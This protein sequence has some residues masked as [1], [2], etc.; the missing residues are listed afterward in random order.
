MAEAVASN[1]RAPILRRVGS[2]F[3]ILSWA[4]TY[5]RRWLRPD[6]VAGVTVAAFAIPEDMAYASLAGL[7]PQHA[8]YANL[9][10]LLVYAA[11]GTSRQLSY[12]VTSALSIMVAGTLGTMAFSSPD[13]YAA[14]AA[15]VAILSGI[16]ALLAGLFRIGFIVNFVSESVLTGFSAGAALYIAASQVSKLFGI[17]GVQGNFFERIWN[18]LRNIGDTN[19]WTL[20]VGAMS[21]AALL[22]LERAFPRLP[23]SLIV[24]IIAIAVMWTSNLEDR[25][26]EVAG[27]IPGGLPTPAWPSIASDQLNTLVVLAFGAFLL[28]Y[29]EGVGA[30]RT[31][32][33]RH[34]YHI[35]SNQELFAN[36]GANLAA[37]MLQ[38][39]NV[40][41]SMSRSAVNE[42]AGSRTPMSSLFAA[43]VLAL[44]LLFLTEPFSHL[45]ETTLAAIVIVA[46]KGLIDI[47][48]LK[49]LFDISRAEFLAALLTMLGVLTFGMLGGIIIGVLVSFLT[50]LKRVSLPRISLL[51]LNPGTSDF[52]DVNHNPDAQVFP[53][54]AVFRPDTGLFY[55]NIPVI[56]DELAKAIEQREEP[57]RLVV[58]DLASAPMVDLETVD[59]LGEIAD[60]LDGKEI[61]LRLA[62][63]HTGVHDLLVKAGFTDRHGA[64]APHE[65]IAEVIASWRVN[66]NHAGTSTSIPS[67]ERS[68]HE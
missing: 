29:V 12:S 58:V 63:V 6:L 53:D 15:M 45:P 34:K 35:D 18:V 37:G 50:V 52:V 43:V 25:G 27:S 11:M 51:G 19:G 26:I 13:Q 55:G 21:M 30:A 64:V 66:G 48:G 56:K 60:D 24:T 22:A 57:P 7:Q 20:A 10:A 2:V 14:A 31:F 54:I 33:I 49:R 3:P 17:S 39:Y 61:D 23:T 5:D 41:G 9:V 59:T 4:R 65:N 28:S 36:G 32:A 16:M 67:V 62:N 40:G 44:V 46:V 38:G 8:L 42:S 68:A 1:G 47:P